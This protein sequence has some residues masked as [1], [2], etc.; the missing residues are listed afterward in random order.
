MENVKNYVIDFIEGRVDADEFIKTCQTDPTIFDWIQ[1]IVPKDEIYEQVIIVTEPKYEEIC[2]EVPYD[3]RLVFKEY[4]LEDRG[5]Y[6]SKKMNFHAEIS[7]LVT[8][9]FPREDIE[10][11]ES[12]SE[13]FDFLLDACPEY[14]LSVDI[15]GSGILEQLMEEFPETMPKTKRIKAFKEK[16]KTM[17]YIEGNK[18]PRWIQESEWPLSK[19]GKPTKFLRQKSKGEV[20]Y[21][22][23]LDMDTGEEI[24]IMQAD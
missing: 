17:F 15:E 11:D 12:L 16:L 9:A 14:L 1:S 10:E 19:T 20:S 8:E 24:E 5:S 21:Y 6:L 4:V 3:I 18:F 13:L 22:Y 7:R 2:K 23:F